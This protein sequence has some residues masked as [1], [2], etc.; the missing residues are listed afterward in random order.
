MQSKILSIRTHLI[1]STQH[2]FFKFTKLRV[3]GFM[4]FNPELL[5]TM[6]RKEMILDSIILPLYFSS[7]YSFWCAF[8][9]KISNRNCLNVGAVQSLNFK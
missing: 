9:L 4:I 3:A 6:I 5:E 2:F 7:C 1:F 8:S